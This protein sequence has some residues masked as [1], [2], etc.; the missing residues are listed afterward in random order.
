V[1]AQT[2]APDPSSRS[3]EFVPVQGGGDTTSA[4]L[5]LV[6]A[7]LVMWAILLGFVGLGWRRQAKLETRLAELERGISGKAPGA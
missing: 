3:Q 2:A 6:I 1:N 7:Y 4:E 5:L